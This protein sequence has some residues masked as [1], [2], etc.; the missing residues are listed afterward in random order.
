MRLHSQPVRL[1]RYLAAIISFAGTIGFLSWTIVNAI[2]FFGVSNPS[3]QLKVPLMVSVT[4]LFLAIYVLFLIYY[5]YWSR[6]TKSLLVTLYRRD[7]RVLFEKYN[8]VFINEDLVNDLGHNP[9]M[10][11]RLSQKDKRDVL[12]GR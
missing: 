5:S 3:W 10:L 9:K 8:R 1:I 4:G 11:R 12:I 6:K 7:K 2:K